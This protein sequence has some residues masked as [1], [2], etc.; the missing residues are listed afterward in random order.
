MFELQVL[1]NLKNTQLP[2]TRSFWITVGPSID[3]P[4]AYRITVNTRNK[5][6][7][8]VSTV[9][10]EINDGRDLDL[11]QLTDSTNNTIKLFQ[12]TTSVDQE[13]T[14]VRDVDDKPKSIYDSSNDKPTESID[15]SNLKDD[16]LQ[17]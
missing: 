3:A 9:I 17:I 12:L 8:V 16:H 6:K 13:S 10:K 1:I 5:I 14:E 4:G 7:I 11:Y 15:D 2:S